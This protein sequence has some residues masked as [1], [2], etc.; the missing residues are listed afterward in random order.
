M[1]KLIEQREA[2]LI[3]VGG[4]KAVIVPAPYLAKLELEENDTIILRLCTG[5]NGLFF[6]GYKKK[7]E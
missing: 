3:N 7:G 5:K 1:H 4:S 6:D 2:R